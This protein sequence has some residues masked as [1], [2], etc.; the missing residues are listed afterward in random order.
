[1]IPQVAISGDGRTVVVGAINHGPG[2]TAR[3][4][5]SRVPLT[6]SG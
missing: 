6:A 3:V 4:Y 2:G 5:H 1:M